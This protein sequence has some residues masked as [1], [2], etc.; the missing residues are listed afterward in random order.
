MKIGELVKRHGVSVDTIR[1]YEKQKLLS[2][3]ARS[4]AG[5]RLYN[6][7]DSQRLGFILRAKSVGFSLQ[8]IRELLQIED[9]KSEW[10]CADVKDKVQHKMQDI[11]QQIAELRRFHQALQQLDDA[12]CGG[13]LSATECSILAALEKGQPV[14][15]EHHHQERT[16]C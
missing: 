2:P 4:E 12:C 10:Q 5:Y 7:A 14:K 15:P 1:F 9:N 3:S 8:Q 11:E 6:E 13:P 16:S